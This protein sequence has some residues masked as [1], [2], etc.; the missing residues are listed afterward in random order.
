MEN[1]GN[2]LILNIQRMSTEDGP[3]LRTTVFFKGCN[4]RCAW[5]HNPESLSRDRSV[6]WF[7]TRCIRC[8]ICAQ[9]C[10]QKGITVYKDG[11]ARDRSRCIKCGECA[12]HCPVLA[13]EIKG[14]EW[15]LNALVREVLKDRDYFGEDGGI[16]ASGGECLLQSDFVAAFFE[17]LKQENVHTALDTAG[18][19]PWDRFEKTLPFSDMILLDLKLFDADLHRKYTKADNTLILNN[20]VRLAEYIGNHPEKKLWIRTPVIPNMTD[21]E[22]NIFKIGA[23]IKDSI[24]P[25]LDKWELLAFNNLCADKYERLDMKWDLNDAELMKREKMEQI[26]DIALSACQNEEIVCWS[27]AVKTEEESP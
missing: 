8:G 13:T 5:C 26:Y 1:S 12:Q 7:P 17:K 16:T 9:F 25:S 4:L 11:V 20:A 15:E 6:E 23:F 3:G 19:V 18:N 22:D 14:R 21:S 24:L 2:A 27:G 10:S